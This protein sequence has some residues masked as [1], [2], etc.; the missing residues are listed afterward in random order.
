LALELQYAPQ[1]LLQP[2]PLEPQQALELSRVLELLSPPWAR[3]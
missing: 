2:G 1:L 3:Y